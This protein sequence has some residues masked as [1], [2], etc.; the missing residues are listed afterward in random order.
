MAEPPPPPDTSLSQSQWPELTLAL[1][2]FSVSAPAVAVMV[3]VAAVAMVVSLDPGLSVPSDAS[4]DDGDAGEGDD[5]T[6]DSACHQHRRDQQVVVLRALG[7]C[8]G[9]EVAGA[10]V[11]CYC[12]QREG[13]L[14][15][16]PGLPH[17]FLL[18]P[19]H[20]GSHL[21]LNKWRTV[22]IRLFILVAPAVGEGSTIGASG[23]C[24]LPSFLSSGPLLQEPH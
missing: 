21:S 5:H 12:G 10:V 6:Y 19:C 22:R 3:M 8:G 15:W 11:S 16:V 17:T 23:V 14:S 18:Q 20:P 2:V 9:V 4:H 24:R 13:T 1:L 7:E